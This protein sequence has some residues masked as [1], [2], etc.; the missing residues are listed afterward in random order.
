MIRIIRTR[1]LD[2]LHAENA[3][4]RAALADTQAAATAAS[5]RAAAA[6]REHPCPGEH[7]EATG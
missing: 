6:R 3:W 5:H 1:D 4:L 2:A 7:R